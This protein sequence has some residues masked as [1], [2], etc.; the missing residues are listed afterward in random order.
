MTKVAQLISYSKLP[1]VVVDGTGIVCMALALMIHGL[2]TK[3]WGALLLPGL[4]L[5]WH[6]A[7]TWPGLVRHGSNGG[8]GRA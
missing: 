4:L 5:L 7:F 6:T 2:I 8:R 3:A 1:L